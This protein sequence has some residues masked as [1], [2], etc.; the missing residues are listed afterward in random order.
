MQRCDLGENWIINVAAEKGE[1]RLAHRGVHGENEPLQQVAWKVRGPRFHEFLKQAQL[2]AWSFKAWVSML[3]P[4]RGWRILV[5]KGKLPVD[6]QYGN[7]YLKSTWGT[8]LEG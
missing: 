2:K 8:Q 7:S 6:Q 3:G 5:L 4:G 1:G